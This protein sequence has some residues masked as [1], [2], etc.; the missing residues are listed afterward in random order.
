MVG[1]LHFSKSF[2]SRNKETIIHMISTGQSSVT[3]WGGRNMAA[4][5]DRVFLCNLHRLIEAKE[6]FASSK[7]TGVRS[8]T[9]ESKLQFPQIQK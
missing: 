6:T 1:N 3:L 7:E 9:R 4:Y 8:K 2:N 5:K